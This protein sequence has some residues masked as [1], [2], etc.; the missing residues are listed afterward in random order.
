MTGAVE[1][2]LE[3]RT[4]NTRVIALEEAEYE[5]PDDDFSIQHYGIVSCR[6]CYNVMLIRR[7]EKPRLL[8]HSAIVLWP[9]ADRILNK[10]VPESLRLEHNEARRCFRSGAYT[11]AVVMVRRTLEGVCAEHGITVKNLVRGLEQM[12]REKLIDDRLFEWAQ[13]LRVLGNEGAH[14]TGNR[15]SRRDAEDAVAMAEA[16]LDYLYVFSA[17]FNEFKQRRTETMQAESMTT[18]VNGKEGEVE[19]EPQQ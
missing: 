12:K 2:I 11:A 14:F 10:A 6:I 4:C 17:K 19:T 1:Y 9:G 8:S 15:V 16:I 5:C 3:C 13:E 7:P 18:V